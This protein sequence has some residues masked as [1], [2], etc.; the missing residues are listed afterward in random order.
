M[1]NL[2]LSTNLVIGFIGVTLSLLSFSMHNM[3]ALRQ[4]AIFSNLAF[5]VY[6]LLES[7]LPTVVLSSILLPLNAWRLLEIKRLVKDIER[8]SADTPIS[9]WLLPHMSARRCTAGQVL[10]NQGDP[11]NELY[12]IQQGTVRL[13][14]MNIT[15]GAGE[16]FGEMGI[17]ST[18][19]L[20]TLG[21]VCQTDCHLYTLTRES[22]Y[23]L[24][25]Q[26]PKLGFHLIS[27]IVNR[28]TSQ[29]TTANASSQIQPARHPAALPV[30]GA[31]C[32]PD[33]NQ[34]PE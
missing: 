8:A 10:F 21:A 3:Q 16:L 30:A 18:T 14:E 9:E 7:V 20:R 19:G 12:F 13:R 29:L 28:L 15:L 5:I 33:L 1:T 6:G 4:V 2:T 23:K 26:Q 32:G 25:Y 11:A 17:F 22:V 27:L 34:S 31:R 24:Y